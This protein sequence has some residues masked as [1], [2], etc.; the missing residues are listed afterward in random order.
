MKSKN[1]IIEIIYNDIDDLRHNLKNVSSNDYAREISE[2]SRDS[3]LKWAYNDL[4][5]SEAQ[6]KKMV[7]KMKEVEDS[8]LHEMI[9]QIV[10]SKFL[11]FSEGHYYKVKGWP[12]YWN[13]F[14]I[15]FTEKG[16]EDYIKIL[17]LQG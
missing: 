13:R 9:R 6:K 1:E 17:Q 7:K 4:P 10:I 12:F 14:Y 2:E 15:H 11:K 16:F 8:E 3:M 5:I